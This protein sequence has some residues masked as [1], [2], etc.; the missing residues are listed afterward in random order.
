[1]NSCRAQ[2]RGQGRGLAPTPDVQQAGCAQHV[3]QR[4]TAC[5][6][7]NCHMNSQCASWQ[8]PHLWRVVVPN[9]APGGRYIAKFQNFQ[10]DSPKLTAPQQAGWP[11]PLPA[12]V[13]SWTNVLFCRPQKLTVPSWQ[14]PYL[15]RVVVPNHARLAV[16]VLPTVGGDTQVL[17]HDPEVASPG[18]GGV[19]LCCWIG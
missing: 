6:A 3:L 15:R 11:C 18:T 19:V 12:A 16:D 5:K 7:A 10:I 2:E 4:C 8:C 17:Q 14:Y 1:M 9:A 13:H